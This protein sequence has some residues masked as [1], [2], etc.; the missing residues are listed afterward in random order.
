[1]LDLESRGSVSPKAHLDGHFR[2]RGAV[3]REEHARRP[4]IARPSHEPLGDLDEKRTSDD[5]R[6][7]TKCIIVQ[8]RNKINSRQLPAQA[9]ASARR[10]ESTVP[11]KLEPREMAHRTWLH[12]QKANCYNSAV[13]AAVHEPQATNSAREAK[14][15]K[16][17]ICCCVPHFADIRQRHWSR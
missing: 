7:E 1:M 2:R 14:R 4:T 10:C 9:A 12:C 11:S 15:E 16:T 3:V 13:A 5:G 6:G 8:W 17:T